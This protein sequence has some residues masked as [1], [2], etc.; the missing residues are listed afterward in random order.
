MNDGEINN[1]SDDFYPLIYNY[2]DRWCE[3]CRFNS[4]CLNYTL[5]NET[6]TD[7]SQD[8]IHK[9]IQMLF[10]EISEIL[11]RFMVEEGLFI[12]DFPDYSEVEGNEDIENKVEA[13]PVVAMSL[14]YFNDVY[15]WFADNSDAIESF[16]R[17]LNNIIS[18][19]NYEGDPIDEL[20]SLHD[21]VDIITYYHSFIYVKLKRAV[22]D[23]TNKNI[24]E[25][26]EKIDS[27][28]SAKLA[29]IAIDRSIDS[30]NIMRE[31]LYN[32][33]DIIIPDF[34]GK[35]IK[36][37]TMAEDK[38]PDARSFVRPYFDEQL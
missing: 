35:L 21:V 23:V 2:C 37:R 24:D 32:E 5:L 17:R 33:N 9:K 16:V 14:S 18:S 31:I 10:D 20:L 27:N 29:L 15:Q 13:S 25:V 4:R 19:G 3:R 36:L 12:D 22:W 7:E 6:M 30:W 8:D 11:E 1:F 34:A 28:L 38:F 26:F